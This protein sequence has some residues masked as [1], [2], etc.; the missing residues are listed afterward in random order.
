MQEEENDSGI[1]EID[2]SSIAIPKPFDPAKID[3]TVQSLNIDLVIKRLKSSPP[4]IDLMP[5]FQRKGN[6]WKEREQSRL[7]ESIMVRIPLPAF[8]F[9]ASTE[10]KWLV[11][12]GLQR[13]SVLNNFMVKKTLRLTELEYLTQYN[14]F[15]F[16]NL[17][18]FIQGRI[19]ETNI[20][21]YLIRPGTPPEVKFT[22]FQRINTGGLT[23]TAQEI[24]HALNQGQAA[25]FLQEAAG[26]EE[27]LALLR[28]ALKKNE[29]M[30]A[31][32]FVNRF[33]AFYLLREQYK[34]DIE[35]FL[36]TGMEALNKVETRVLGELKI[37]FKRALILADKLFDKHAFRRLEIENQSRRLQI[38]KALFDTVSVN[39]ALL[40][41]A[42]GKR[43][44]AQKD[45]FIKG[46]VEL[47]NDPDFEKSIKTGTSAPTAVKT[48]FE[49][50]R[51]L[52]EKFIGDDKNNRT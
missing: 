23:L 51:K 40:S 50:L 4:R 36:N 32:E 16:D 46:F 19:E 41:E 28:S 22:I 39:L 33:V 38:N 47:N 18:G 3:I 13:L 25:K 8:Y 20:T 52:I 42:E 6:L 21:A 29:R 43:L 17:P 11:V 15:S 1:E 5:D 35:T 10:E 12:D 45:V 49:K 2:E 48:R 7:I 44:L 30:E 14:G 9:D 24:R 34:P 26:W 27:F 37:H 31:E